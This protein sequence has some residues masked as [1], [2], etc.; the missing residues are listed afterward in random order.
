MISWYPVIEVLKQ[1][2][3]TAWPAAPTPLPQKTV[4]SASTSAAVAQRGAAS[5]TPAVLGEVMMK[6]PIRGARAASPRTRHGRGDRR[7]ARFVAK[8]PRRVKARKAANF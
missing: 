6:L 4:P 2:S 8:P 3:P 1:T 7:A 5:G